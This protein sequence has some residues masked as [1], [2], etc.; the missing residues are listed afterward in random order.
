MPFQPDIVAYC[1]AG[2]VKLNFSTLPTSDAKTQ[3][4]NFIES[5]GGVPDG[6]WYLVP[7][8]SVIQSIIVRTRELG[9]TVHNLDEA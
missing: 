1:S 3:L 2:F 8:P 5:H 9:G 7:D 6:D 4:I